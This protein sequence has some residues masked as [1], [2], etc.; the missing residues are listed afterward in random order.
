MPEANE[1]IFSF[2]EI[3]EHLVKALNI[4]QGLWGV[5]IR[6]GLGAANIGSEPGADVF[7]TAIV[8][9]KEIGLR[10]Y[11]EASNLTVD[12]AEVNPAPKAASKDASKK[13]TK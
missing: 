1:Y 9:V 8:P 5:Q 10:R 12:A 4:H 7:P 2:K 3:A 11:D 13:A 6:F